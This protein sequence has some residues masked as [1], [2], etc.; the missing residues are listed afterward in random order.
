MRVIGM[1][2]GI[3]EDD[4]EAIRDQIDGGMRLEEGEAPSSSDGMGVMDG[5]RFAE[6]IDWRAEHPSGDLMTELLN[7]NSKTPRGPFGGS[8]G[9]RF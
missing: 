6:Y 3:P 8:L 4:Q 1:L 9:K 2:L 7:A 5:S